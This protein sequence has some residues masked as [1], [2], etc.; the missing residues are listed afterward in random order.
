M[1]IDEFLLHLEAFH[2]EFSLDTSPQGRADKLIEEVCEFVEALTIS[3]Q[4]HADD[5]AIDV[6]V[7]AISNVVCRG[8][9]NPLF[10]AYLKLQRTAEKYRQQQ[11]N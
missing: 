9:H 4:E 10:A 1:Q 7:C 8:I 11:I 2:K 5:E 6:L 3:T